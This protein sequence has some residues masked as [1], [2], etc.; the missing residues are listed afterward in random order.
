VLIYFDRDTIAHVAKSLL[1][2]IGD[3]GWLVLGAKIRRSMIS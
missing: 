1:A 3:D 2:S